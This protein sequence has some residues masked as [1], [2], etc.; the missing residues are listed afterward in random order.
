VRQHAGVGPEA[1]RRLAGL[2]ED[3]G[4]IAQACVMCEGEVVVELSSGCRPDSLFLLFSAGKPLTA[5]LVHLLAERGQLR[6]D[7]PVARYW[8]EFGRHGKGTVT[9]RQVP[10]HRA[11]VPAAR[12]LWR[13]ALAAPSW[14]RSVRAPENARP[15]FPPGQVPAYHI[16]SYGFILGEVVQRVT[17]RDLRAVPRAE[18]LDP[19]GPAGTYLG[20]PA[21]LWSRHVPV[22]TSGT[23]GRPGSWCP[24]GALS[25]R[26][27]PRPPRCPAP[28]G[29]WP[30]PTRC[31]RTAASS[32]ASASWLRPP[33]PGPAAVG[34][35]AG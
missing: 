32:T 23:G 26:R 20:L 15:R 18:V 21:P 35:R 17:G 31:C 8:P 12:G 25:A 5:V 2:I 4:A 1:M 10:Q 7:D 9:V 33:W 16:L 30:A 13:D 22:V 28:P 11:G 6:L 3:R 24:A 34:R 14:S 27:S 29:T 19:L